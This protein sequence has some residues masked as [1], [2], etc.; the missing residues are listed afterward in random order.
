MDLRQILNTLTGT[1]QGFLLGGLLHTTGAKQAL[2][3]CTGPWIE[4]ASSALQALAAADRNTRIVLLQRLSTQLATRIP[5]RL[6][7]IHPSWFKPLLIDAP[8]EIAHA[9]LKLLPA[10]ARAEFDGMNLTK[11]SPIPATTALW[12][13]A[14]ALG[15]LESM[16][17]QNIGERADGVDIATWPAELLL[18]TMARTGY[19]VV[20]QY[21]KLAGAKM[22]VQLSRAVPTTVSNLIRKA[23]S[24]LPECS[25]IPRNVWEDLSSQC[26]TALRNVDQTNVDHAQTLN[27]DSAVPN[28]FMALGRAIFAKALYPRIAQKVAQRLPYE[29]GVSIVK[30][31]TA[32]PCTELIAF[33]RAGYRWANEEYR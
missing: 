25:D 33:I 27:T 16:P 24:Y 18:E 14:Y 26:T 11:A 22:T 31:T 17:P 28:A 32:Q 5:E 7:A 9:V 3:Q 13:A 6:G 2:A 15:T 4:H 1:E 12:L 29:L 20:A 23:D 19:L 21:A 30:Q 8:P 10:T